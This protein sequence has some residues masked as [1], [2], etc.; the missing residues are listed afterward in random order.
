MK[1]ME[2]GNTEILENGGLKLS[3][4]TKNGIIIGLCLGVGFGGLYG[5][6]SDNIEILKQLI[7]NRVFHLKLLVM[8]IS[9][10]KFSLTKMRL[11]F[12]MNKKI[13]LMFL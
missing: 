4:K 13:Q 8:L 11:S 9:E 5:R 7:T 2:V 3:K 6:Y 12:R 1:D 10:I